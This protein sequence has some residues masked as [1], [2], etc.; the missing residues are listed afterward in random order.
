MGNYPDI[1]PLET[2]LGVIRQQLAQMKYE[3]KE[4]TQ[5]YQ[6]LLGVAAN[7]KDALADVEAG[8]NAGA[9]DTAQLDV[10]IKGTQ[11]LLQLWAQWS[12]LSKQLGVENKDLDKAIGIITQML[13][14][15]VAIQS[16]QNML[17]KQSIVMQKAQAVATWA[18]TKAETARTS[19]MAAGTVATNAGTAAVWKFTAALFANPIGVIVAA[20]IAAIA[21]VYALVKA[22]SWFNSS[23]E[24][25]KRI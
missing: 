3:G 25:R 24:K 6:D 9:S 1:K 2:Q 10:L 18:Q 7:M 12:I 15:L 8:I 13:G 11:N 17:Q 14:A 23:T 19:A 4:T 20:I 5:E 22:F 16:V 21:A